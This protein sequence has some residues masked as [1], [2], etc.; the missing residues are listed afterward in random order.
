MIVAA[1]I[2]RVLLALHG[3]TVLTVRDI[4]PAFAITGSICLIAVFFLW[5]LERHAGAEVSGHW[6]A[7]TGDLHNLHGKAQ[8]VLNVQRNPKAIRSS[9]TGGWVAR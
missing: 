9:S 1:Q 3:G 6:P 2:L 5:P 4:S 7:D 8:K